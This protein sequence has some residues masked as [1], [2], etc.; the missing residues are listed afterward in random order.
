MR[1]E[2]ST[3]LMSLEEPGSPIN[4]CQVHKSLVTTL[5]HQTF[6]SILVFG[7]GLVMQ[8]DSSSIPNV[9]SPLIRTF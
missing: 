5:H 9:Y 4:T 8:L 3:T 7:I 1:G 6:V 2:Q